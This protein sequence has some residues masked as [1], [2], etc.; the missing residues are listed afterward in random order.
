MNKARMLELADFIE[1]SE[2][3]DQTGWFNLCGTPACIAGHAVVCSGKWISYREGS[4]INDAGE[5]ETVGRAASDWLELLRSQAVD[6]F[7][8]DPFESFYPESTAADAAATLRRAA[9]TGEIKWIRAGS[10]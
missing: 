5:I 7:D 6:L 10:D 9:E 8:A 4:V 2:T 3:F 1:K